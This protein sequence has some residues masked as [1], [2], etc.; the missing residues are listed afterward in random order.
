MRYA[1]ATSMAGLVAC[2]FCREMCDADE[3]TTCPD[4]GLELTA[5]SKLPPR[6][7]AE[8]DEEAV[9][10]HMETLPWTFAG[11]NR[12]LLLALAITGLAMFFAPWVHETAPE[13]RTMS[14]FDLAQMLGWMWAPAV[15]WFVLIP[16]VASRRSIYKMRGAR[17]AV[18]FLAAIV[19]TTVGVRLA[20]EPASSSLRPVRLE[21]AWG[22][23]ASGAVGIAAVIAALGFG[24]RIDD[25]PTKQ[26]RRGGET[27]H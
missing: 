10:P 22:L 19:I 11:R 4:C 24:G 6:A 14:G 15:A 25:V 17:V 20:F 3:S 1:L 9:P 13:L 7:H 26:A 21:W 12:A 18:A 27:L 23:Y 5:A 16:L 2:P 8:L